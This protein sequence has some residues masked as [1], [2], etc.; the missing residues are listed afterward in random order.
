MTEI[1]NFSLYS[2]GWKKERKTSVSEKGRRV[3]RGE[4]CDYMV[5]SANQI[6]LYWTGGEEIYAGTF[7]PPS[8]DSSMYNLHNL[9][10]LVML[11]SAHLQP[12]CI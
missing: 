5:A 1:E 11:G 7:R 9:Y 4:E 2:H 6:W 3:F 8:R 10:N 12:L